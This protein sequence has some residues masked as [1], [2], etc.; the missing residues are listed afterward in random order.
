MME[1]VRKNLK[2]RCC[3]RVITYFLTCCLILNTSLPVALATP[4][5]GAFTV[6][7]GTILQDVADSVVTVNQAQSVIEWGTLGV[8]GSGGIDTA[9]GE[10]LTFLQKEGLGLSNSAVLNR[11]MSGDQTQFGGVLNGQ[12]MRIFIVNPAGIVFESGSSVNVAQLV[13]SGL[14]MSN[15]AFLNF[16]NETTN[17]M[18]FEDGDGNVINSGIINATDSI[19]LIGKKVQNNTGIFAPGGVVVLAAGDSVY[20]THEDSNVLVEVAVLEDP[21]NDDPD[22]WNRSS[23]NANEG[24]IILAAGDTFSRAVVNSSN[25]TARGGTITAHAARVENNHVIDVD[26]YPDGDGGNVTLIG[27]EKVI[28]G[29]GSTIIADAGVTGNGGEVILQ[30]EGTDTVEGTVTIGED[31]LIRVK[32]GS[33]IGD[34]GS[35]KITAEHFSIAGDIDASAT[36][37]QAGTLHIDPATV[38]IASGANPGDPPLDTL[39]EEDIETLSQTGTNLVIEAEE[40]I[41]VEDIDDNEIEGGVGGIALLATGEDSSVIFEDT[42]Q[43]I[44]PL[45]SDLISTTLGDI[46]IK[47]GS[48]GINI[49]SLETGKEDNSE[50]PFPGKILLTTFNKG[51]ITTDNLII[52]RGWGLAE[53]NVNSSS[54]LTVNGDVIVG[55]ND[56][57]NVP[58][59]QAAEAMIYLSAEDNVELFG[60]VGAYAHG[61]TQAEEGSVT[62]AYIGISAGTNQNETGDLTIHEDLVADAQTSAGGKSEAI[63]EIDTWG[64]ITWL[65]GAQAF[66]VADGGRPSGAAVSGTSDANDLN[67]ESGDHAQI[68][69]N[70]LG[71]PLPLPI[72]IFDDALTSKND[73]AFNIDVLGNDTQGGEP[74]VGGSVE[75]GTY[76]NPEGTLETVEVD[77]KIVSFN[78]TPPTDAVYLDQGDSDDNGAY[79][80][81]TTSFDY[82]AQDSTG[83]KVSELPATVTI[84]VTNYIPAAEGDSDTI[85]MS[86]AENPTDTSFNLLDLVSDFDDETLTVTLVGAVDDVVTT[87]NGGTVTLVDGT[88]TYEPPDGYANAD[89]FEY[90]VTDGQTILDPGEQPVEVT[91][92]ATIIMDNTLPEVTDFTVTTNMDVPI[93]GNVLTNANATDADGDPL[94]LVLDGILREN[95]EV[96]LNPDGTFTF[97][98][99]EGFIG[100]GS[101]T[102]KIT[103]GQLD[104]ETPVVVTAT[105]TI[106]VNQPPTPPLP[107][108]IPAAP[109]LERIEIEVSGCP[110]LV[111]WAAEELG[112]N[113]K[114][115]EIWIANAL[116]S[117]RDIQPCNTCAS[118][119]QAATILQDAEGTHIAAL[120]Q[121]INEFASS[122][123]PPTEEQMASIADAIANNTEADNQYFIAG[124]YLDA[125]AEYVGILNMDMNFSIEESI[126]LAMEKYVGQLADSDNAGLAAYVAA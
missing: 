86:T 41:I 51:D 18:V 116:A 39:Y 33:T 122:T 53:I 112:V 87:A 55:Q 109:G 124:Q 77:G 46:E 37:G 8:S 12:D 104:G 27:K 54:D 123:A 78:Y 19:Y 107:S 30:S 120:A 52:D 76:T 23:I 40:S 16:L 22:V 14:G 28:L 103:D 96:T 56:I 115:M 100:D 48:D 42:T 88:A 68:I 98:P 63:I 81:F 26:G 32:G 45:I 10:T 21:L 75:P 101:F 35:V 90:S 108:Y 29:A 44:T 49:G 114:M 64:D 9:A 110:A 47:A 71:Y 5:G 92:I 61:T 59:G 105:V 70:E 67:V 3:R 118:L 34:G 125:L 15:E 2:G 73:V 111:T 65:D 113:E 102:F 1:S 7:T 97:T 11:M 31:A 13:A 80:V 79:A 57:L 119:K 85:H 6:G 99:N 72:A 60:E 94:S 20:L 93:T 82:Y 4:S 69:I 121:V 17:E 95:G 91:A 25:L 62:F 74:L 117:T 89:T 66:A 84:T 126:E 24:S 58:N 38:T 106:T 43:D 50:K 36:D 83:E